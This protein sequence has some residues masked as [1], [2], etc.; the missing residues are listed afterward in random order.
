MPET[1]K[2][3]PMPVTT[4]TTPAFDLLSDLL[5]VVRISGS[6]FWRWDLGAPF[7]ISAAGRDTVERLLACD[8]RTQITAFHLIAEGTCAIDRPGQGHDALQ[9]GDIV[10]LPFGDYHELRNG[11]APLVPSADLVAAAGG[12]EGMVTAIPHGGEGARTTIVCG[13][14]QSGDLFFNPI[15]R[16][17]PPLIVEHTVR[18][19]VTSLL[20]STVRQLLIE[21]DA[22]RPGSREMLGRMMEV[23]FLEMLR[24]HVERQ[25]AGAVGWL[26]ALADPIASRVLRL[27]HAEPMRD[28]TV[29][30]L[31]AE[32]GTSR[33]VLAERFKAILGQPPMQYLAG[34]RLQLAS[35]M[36]REG[37]RSVAEVAC[38]VGYESEAAFSRAF[39]RRLGAPPGLWRQ[40]QTALRA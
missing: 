14:V 4:V 37:S 28:W 16:G 23:L 9:A 21:V 30:L 22:M 2:P 25:P 10:M 8:R 3:A 7:A 38:E 12:R 18:E 29:E 39:K 6:V 13:F 26:G 20:A 31:A 1:P 32:V 11:D 24:R 36:L 35:T 15:F 40:N 27:I 33:T 17:L 5:R 19:P 34:W